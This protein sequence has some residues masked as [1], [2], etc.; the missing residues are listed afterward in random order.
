MNWSPFAWRITWTS[1]TRSWSQY[2]HT[3][4]Q[5]HEKWIFIHRQIS[6]DS[7]K[8][9]KPSRTTQSSFRH[10]MLSRIWFDL[11]QNIENRVVSRFNSIIRMAF[12]IIEICLDIP[13]WIRTKTNTSPIDITIITVGTMYYW[14]CENQHA[15]TTARKLWI[16]IHGRSTRKTEGA[17]QTN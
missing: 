7:L 5:Q 10:L 8:R 1:P 12:K 9:N 11:Q 2:D 14:T 13:Q 16:A 6:H 3:F 4:W 17:T 15:D